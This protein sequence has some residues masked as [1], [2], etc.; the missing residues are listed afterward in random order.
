MPDSAARTERRKTHLDASVIPV[1]KSF[2]ARAEALEQSLAVP[3]VAAWLAAEYR[4]LAEELH[5]H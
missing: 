4:A 3:T 2:L 5:W 1:E